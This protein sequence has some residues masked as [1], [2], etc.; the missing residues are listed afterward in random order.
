M[1]ISHRK[2]IL[3]GVLIAS[4]SMVP[5]V[6]AQQASVPDKEV[7]LTCDDEELTVDYGTVTKLANANTDAIPGP[8]KSFM[9]ANTIQLEVENADQQYY[10]IT[11][12]SSMKITQLSLGQPESPDL[13]V[14]SDRKTACDIYTADQPAKAFQKEY[15]AGEIDVEANGAVKSAVVSV[16]ESLSDLFL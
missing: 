11:T 16:T 10:T 8:L 15:Q 7:S 2:I 4:V 6:S 5:I 12:D 1:T 14:Q 9:G 3:L 13:L